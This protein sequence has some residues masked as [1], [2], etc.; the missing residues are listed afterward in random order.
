MKS[1]CYPV[2]AKMIISIKKKNDNQTIL[3]YLGCRKEGICEVRQPVI[4]GNKEGMDSE[5]GEFV[6]FA[7]SE[8][9]E[10]TQ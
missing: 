8:N 6:I 3:H 5:Y 9:N 2:S 1:W 4:A 7:E 10:R